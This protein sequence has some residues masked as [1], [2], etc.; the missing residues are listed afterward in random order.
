MLAQTA[1]DGCQAERLSAA[2]L[3]A[4]EADRTHPVLIA[5]AHAAAAQFARARS[6][7]WPSLPLLPPLAAG[8][9]GSGSGGRSGS[10]DL[11]AAAVG[12]GQVM[13]WAT[14]QLLH[15]FPGVPPAREREFMDGVL[16]V[17][18]SWVALHAAT[19]SQHFVPPL[20]Y[21]AEVTSGLFAMRAGDDAR[22][23]AHVRS[24]T[25]SAAA[26]GPLLI[27]DAFPL[28]AAARLLPLLRRHGETRAAD[29]LVALLHASPHIAPALMADVAA[30]EDA[31]PHAREIPLV[32]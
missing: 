21:F 23:L 28:V 14:G 16:R 5:L 11:A 13:G 6:N 29:T 18:A 27:H 31:L 30:G 32:L 1:G 9:G 2:A 8:A 4:V 15:A 22:A 20:A 17:I 7:V 19:G 25:E 3:L 12:I 24:L 26:L 10:V